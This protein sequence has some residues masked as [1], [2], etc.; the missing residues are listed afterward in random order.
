MRGQHSTGMSHVG[1]CRVGP[2]CLASPC[3]SCRSVSADPCVSRGSCHACQNPVACHACRVSC[4]SQCVCGS[5]LWCVLRVTCVMRVV[6]HA[7]CVSCVSHCLRVM[8]VACH[9]CCV[10][11][12]SQCLRVMRVACHACFQVFA[13]RFVFVSKSCV[14]AVRVCFWASLLLAGLVGK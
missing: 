3:G 12:V 8:R 14:F 13:V 4:V 1:S 11:C 10:S 2:E 6:C 9:A 5:L 7:C